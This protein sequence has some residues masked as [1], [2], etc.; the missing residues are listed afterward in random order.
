[1]SVDLQS[2]IREYATWV[3]GRQEPVTLDEIMR[4][5]DDTIPLALP[6]ESRE[7]AVRGPW[8][9]LVAA[10]VV[11]VIFGVFMWVFPTDESVPPADS[12]PP[13]W[14]QETV[15][16][17]TSAVPDGFVLQDVWTIGGSS[18]WYLAEFDDEWLPTDGGFAIHGIE[19]HPLGV[20]PDPNGYLDATIA[21]VPGSTEID[22]D[23]RRAIIFETMLEQ[24][25][26]SVPLT[27]ILS[28][29]DEGGVFEVAT[30]G[31]SRTAALSVIEGVSRQSADEFHALSLG[32]SWDVKVGTGHDDFVYSTPQRITDLADD[33]EV[34]LGM[35][36]LYPRLSGAGQ[37]G[38]VI[39]T[40]DGEVV[41]T[42]AQ[43]IQSSSS[44]H[45]LDLGDRDID[46]ALVAYPAA[47]VSPARREVE[48]DAY[49]DAV[50][51]GEVL[52]ED[53]YVI[54]AAAAPEPVFDV[55]SLGQ[56]LPLEPVESF[57]VVPDVGGLGFLGQVLGTEQ[58]PVIVIG[59]ANRS[60]LDLSPIILMRWFTDTG[61][62]CEGASSGEGMG[63]G[64]GSRPPLAQ[65]GVTSASSLE[66]DDGFAYGEITYNVPLETSVVQAIAGSETFWQRPIGGS[67]LFFY[68]GSIPKA[69]T[70]IAYDADGNE[71]GRWP[72]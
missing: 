2:R 70:I 30:T 72:A 38:T 26:V 34:A 50:A 35:D 62:T 8:P 6:R 37:E 14:E 3:E 44:T 60:Q 27:W 16:Y 17:T 25:E 24:G 32:L 47:E 63:T 7:R 45:Y 66:G 53:P 1:M 12:V 18:V 69:S 67:G 5:S 15:Y 57:E 31:M 28:F 51:G 9:A 13:P 58:R 65:L 54:Q 55:G 33:V 29:D 39:T 4:R 11:L 23:G 19:G 61:S 41:E 64:C 49:I 10:A 42:F 43:A 52:S 40:Q 21:A 48:F 59:S 46:Q 68:G 36:L 71:I 20:P 22:I 56:E